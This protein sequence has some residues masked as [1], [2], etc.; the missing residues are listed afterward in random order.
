MFNISS[1][2][3]AVIF[4]DEVEGEYALTSEQDLQSFYESFDLSSGN[5]KFVIQDLQSEF[6][7][8]WLFL[9][10]TIQLAPSTI[11]STTSSNLSSLSNAG[12]Q[13]AARLIKSAHN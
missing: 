11:A 7:S 12:R 9:L 8:N 3:V 2:N 13:S 1:N 5:I 6:T 10:P 4:I